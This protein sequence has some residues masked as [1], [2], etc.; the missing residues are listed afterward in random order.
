VRQRSDRRPPSGTALRASWL[1]RSLDLGW[2]DPVG[3]RTPA[4]DGVV[5]ALTGLG[6]SA[7]RLEQAVRALAWERAS[8]ISHLDV[9]LD[10]LDALWG[11]VESSGDEPVPRRHFLP[12]PS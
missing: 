11:V 8:D 10:D 5:E 3:W 1:A 4:V 9:V 6:R 2:H 7:D 12:R